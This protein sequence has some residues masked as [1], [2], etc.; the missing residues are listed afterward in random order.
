MASSLEEQRRR[1]AEVRKDFEVQYRIYSPDE[2]GRKIG[3]P[4]QG[5]R[6]DWL[7]DGDS[8]EQGLYMIWPI[9]LNES[10][11]ILDPGTQ[12]A[13]NGVAK[14]YIVNDVLRKSF[15]APRLRQGIRGYFM[16]GPHRVAEAIVTRL[17]AISDDVP[18][19][20]NCL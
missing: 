5:Y 12:V 18:L 8:I 16:E 19:G 6:C 7:Y 13:N 11:S 10:G 3:S 9:F 17:L 15:H 2:G 20:T 14:M 4:Y 1:L